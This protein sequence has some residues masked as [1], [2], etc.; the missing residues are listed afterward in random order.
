[1]GSELNRNKIVRASN[2]LWDEMISHVEM[3]I[4]SHF[5]LPPKRKFPL[6]KELLAN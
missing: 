5:K 2:A 3:Y 6:P 1:M 4:L